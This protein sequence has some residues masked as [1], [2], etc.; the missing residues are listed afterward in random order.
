IRAAL[1]WIT[2]FGDRDG[3]GFVEYGART[4]KGLA[5]QGW[6]DSHDSVFHKD[7]RLAT[8]PIA[9]T[10]VQAYVYGAWRAAAI[11][12]RQLG[13]DDDA[14][15]FDRMAETLRISFDK[16]FFDEE[17]QTYIL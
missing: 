5:N 6:K 16:A 7:G 3:D 11:I 2:R 4:G 15:S 13:K 12:A 17:L 1:N 14:L 9:L 10:E 8:G